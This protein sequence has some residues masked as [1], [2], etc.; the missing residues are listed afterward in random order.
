MERKLKNKLRVVQ[1][2]E[3]IDGPMS[4]LSVSWLCITPNLSFW[5]FVDL[6]FELNCLAMYTLPASIISMNC[7]KIKIF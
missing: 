1:H 4:L 7:F 5:R 6:V 3:V 2:T